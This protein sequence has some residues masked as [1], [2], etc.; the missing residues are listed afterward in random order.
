M[1]RVG[2]RI[3]KKPASCETGFKIIKEIN[4]SSDARTE[5]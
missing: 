5:A 2:K 3:Q 1:K 4:Y